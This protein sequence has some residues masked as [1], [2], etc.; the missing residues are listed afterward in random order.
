MFSLMWKNDKA[1]VFYVLLDVLVF[2]SIPFINMYLIK[3]SIAMLE[4]QADFRLYGPIILAFPVANVATNC[5]HNYFNYKRDVHGSMISVRLYQNIFEKTLNMDYE[6]LL[7]KEISEKRELALGIVDN[8]RF[9]GLATNFH[10]IASNII[11]LAG[12]TVVLSQ[13]DFFI[14]LAV[15]V[16]VAINTLSVMYR[17]KYERSIHLDINPIVRRIGYFMQIGSD[18]SYIKEIKTYLMEKQILTRYVDLHNEAREGID[19][20]RRLTLVGYAIAYVMGAVLNGII[21]IFRISRFGA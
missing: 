20:S 12:I 17:Q 2:S 9:S 3:V 10:N 6:L 5:L 14:L 16:V 19:K 11:I 7:D 1:Y 8:W 13:I 18:F 21:Y 4:T 15:L